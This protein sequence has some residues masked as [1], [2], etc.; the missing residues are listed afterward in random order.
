MIEILPLPAEAK[1]DFCLLNKPL[2]EMYY[3]RPG[4]R[5]FMKLEDKQPGWA[6]CADCKKLIDKREFLALASE[7][8]RNLAITSGVVESESTTAVA[9]NFTMKVYE[10][11]F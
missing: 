1:C 7:A 3:P 8:I 5:R 9:I 10:D 4:P 2:V 11:N 6:A